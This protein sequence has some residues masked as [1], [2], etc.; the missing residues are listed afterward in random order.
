MTANRARSAFTRNQQ[1]QRPPKSPHSSFTLHEKKKKK[2]VKNKPENPF[3]LA[4]K[5]QPSEQP[6]AE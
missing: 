5:P 1:Q 3:N 4:E 6:H 2:I